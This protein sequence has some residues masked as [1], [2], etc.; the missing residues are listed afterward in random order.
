MK[1]HDTVQPTSITEIT[2]KEKGDGQVAG[3]M[4][5]GDGTNNQNQIMM[6]EEI[7]I[8]SQESVITDSKDDELKRDYLILVPEN[9]KTN[10]IPKTKPSR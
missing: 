2:I 6:E 4:E 3:S 5:D 1:E 9:K 8:N 7:F 10:D